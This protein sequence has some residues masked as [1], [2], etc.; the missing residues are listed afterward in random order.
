MKKIIELLN[1][2]CIMAVFVLKVIYLK[3]DVSA[4]NL[5]ALILIC[6]FIGVQFF[7]VRKIKIMNLVFIFSLVAETLNL[8]Y[9]GKND[10]TMLAY[11][12]MHIALLIYFLLY[13]R[14]KKAVLFYEVPLCVFIMFM[15]FSFGF[16][17]QRGV[18][19]YLAM[20][21]Y[22]ALLCINLTLS[23]GVNRKVFT[24]VL[25]LFT[26][27]TIVVWSLVPGGMEVVRALLWLPFLTGEFVLRKG[28]LTVNSESKK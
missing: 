14:D 21:I 13:F 18:G 9:D 17:Q 1:W 24:G 8:I 5:A 12:G 22:S 16:W 28:A 7:F 20:V 15:V 3:T 4:Y 2:A 27:D 10:L 11:L 26:V 6:V 19:I 25:L 23:Y